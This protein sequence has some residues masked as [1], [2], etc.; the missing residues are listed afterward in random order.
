MEDI[1]PTSPLN[2]GWPTAFP[3]AMPPKDILCFNDSKYVGLGGG[4]CGSWC[5]HDP[6]VG[7]GCGD[8]HMCAPS[9]INATSAY[10]PD[11]THTYGA[12]WTRDFQYTVSGAAEL[13]DERSVKASVRSV[14]QP[15][16]LLLV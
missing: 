6:S 13:M 5:T 15:L 3:Y 14:V 8:N 11:A 4:P 2:K 7:P 1:L 9:G 12:Q 16:R 10:T